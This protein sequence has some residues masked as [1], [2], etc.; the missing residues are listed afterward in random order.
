MQGGCLCTASSTLLVSGAIQ[1][2]TAA[3]FFY[4]GRTISRETRT[5]HRG[6]MRAF[7]TWWSGVGTYLLLE[8]VLTIVAATATVPLAILVGSRYLGYVAIAA[9]LWGLTYYVLFLWTG[10]A[11]LRWPLAA[12]F[13]LLVISLIGILAANRPIGVDVE[14]WLVLLRFETPV[15][16]PFYTATLAGF[17]LPPIL[18]SI[19]YLSLWRRATTR[20]QRY[21]IALV[22]LSIILY[23]GS[24]LVVRLGT[25]DWLMFVNLTV[26]GLGTAFAVLF[27]YH[28]PRAIHAWLGLGQSDPY[29]PRTQADQRRLKQEAFAQRCRELV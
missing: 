9:G 26:V 17:A 20:H 1:L 23:L 14:R 18:A 27:A 29:T 28:P 19:G 21:R 7:V 11:A 13:T 15:R 8:G 12:L 22:S 4:A 16:G 24:G 25:N 5:T 6:A 3:S 2:V 10:R